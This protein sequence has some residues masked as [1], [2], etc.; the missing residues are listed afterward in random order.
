MRH[1]HTIV[2]FTWHAY[3]TWMPDRPQG[4]YRNREGL[5]PT[6][7]REAETY[8]ARQVEPIAEFTADAQ[9]VI[10]SA[11][12]ASCKQHDW[13]LICFASDPSHVHALTGW[14]DDRSPEDLQRSIKRTISYTLRDRVAK[15]RWLGRK[16]SRPP[17]ARSQAF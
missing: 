7:A 10:L 1:L 15:R 9:N 4:Y 16:R 12:L 17:C 13:T 3:G 2:L 11:T 14:S 5:T 6:S 8:R